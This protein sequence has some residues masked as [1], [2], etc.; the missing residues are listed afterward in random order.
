MIC[1][2]EDCK[3]N[4]Y[5]KTYCST[6]YQRIKKY[7]DPNY[8]SPNKGFQKGIRN[9]SSSPKRKQE[10]SLF[11]KGR[12]ITEKVKKKIR[13]SMKNKL[14]DPEMKKKWSQAATGRKLSEE[15][16]RKMRETRAMR[17]KSK[18]TLKYK[19]DAVFSQ[20]I[21]LRD[22]HVVG[23]ER[24][25][26]CITCKKQIGAYGQREGHAGHF[27]SRRYTSTRWD[28]QNVNLQCVS[29]NSFNSGEQYKY[30]IAIDE[31][32]GKG[33]AEKLHIKSQMLTKFSEF[34]LDILIK[35]YQEEVKKLKT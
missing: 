33:T 6:H 4:N 26:K 13:R 10:I 20:F 19:L 9:P 17:P 35:H 32:Y 25:G 1:S 15:T 16:K 34:D 11:F 23:D 8:T 18:K 5:A 12:P 7:G 31:K 22:S 2:I 30:S 24:V 14:K 28:E 27:M 29:C 3:K 21:R